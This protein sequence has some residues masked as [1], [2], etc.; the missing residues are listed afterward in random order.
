MPQYAGPLDAVRVQQG[1]HPA[2]Q[3]G[4]LYGPGG[5]PAA[6]AMAGQLEAQQPE[7]LRPGRAAAASQTSAEVPSELPSTSTGAPGRAVERGGE[8]Q[9]A[10]RARASAGSDIEEDSL[11]VAL[12]PDV[13]PDTPPGPVAGAASDRVSRLPRSEI[14]EST[15]SAAL[16]C[17]LV[18]EVDPGHDPVE[19][20]AGEDGHIQ[21]RRLGA[22][23][24]GTAAGP[25][26]GSR[27]GSSPSGVGRAAAEP[28]ER[29]RACARYPRRAGIVGMVEAA[30]RVR[31]A[32]SRPARRARLARRRR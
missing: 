26:A 22:A 13:E 8:R 32:R 11:A 19:Q 5:G 1:Q 27:S 30:V 21:V 18:G 16:A 12:Q 6:P 14:E 7:V 3:V 28:A 20:P 4:D 23:V 15:G 29:R 10:A 17:F 9:R 2:A 24:A 25:A 31:P